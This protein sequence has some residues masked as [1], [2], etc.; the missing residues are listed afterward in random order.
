MKILVI[1]GSYF[2]GKHFVNEAVGENSIT[3]FNRGNRPL[4]MD[5]VTEIHGDRALKDDL[6]KIGNSDFDVVVDF[7]AYEPGNIE[8]VIDALGGKIKQYIFVS[9]VDVYKKG[10]N[11]ILDE[12]AELET[13]IYAGEVGQYIAGKT[14]LEEELVKC[15]KARNIAY[16]S[17]R[18]V[19]IYGPDNYAPRE[20]IFFNWVEKAGQVLAPSDETGYF[21]MVYV[22]DLAKN[23][24][25]LCGNEKAYNIA[26][27]VCGNDVYNYQSFL[28]ALTKACEKEFQII[29]LPVQDIL[30]KGIPLPFP[31]T[32]EESEQYTTVHGEL[33]TGEQISL[34]EGLKMDI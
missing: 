9:T 33:I 12:T 16:T 8:S 11:R 30:N 29:T 21:Q 24:I 22:G 6:L 13:T 34:A 23:I 4:N 19:F 20:G 7:C 2:L 25:G 5:K 27:N 15:C 18:P 1:G 26:V 32:A 3:V 10:T 28:E 14:A 17:V 31:L